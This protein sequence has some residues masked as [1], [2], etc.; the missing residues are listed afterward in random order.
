MVIRWPSR[1]VVV[2]LAGETV[3]ALV[4]LFWIR[5]RGLVVQVGEPLVGVGFGLGAAALFAMLNYGVLRL[6]PPVEPVRALRGLYAT[7]LRPVFATASAVDVAVVSLAA[8]IGEELLFR[9]AVQAEFGTLIA[10]LL[11]GLAHIGGRDSWVFGVWVA[12]MGLGLGGLAHLGGGLLA[13][14][15]AHVVYDAAAIEYIRR[16]AARH[17]GTPLW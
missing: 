14:V 6:A 1:L 9:G 12:V 16:D 13:P 4:A 2:A 3:L 11:F 7:T 5:A 15:V 8:G 17:R 10:S